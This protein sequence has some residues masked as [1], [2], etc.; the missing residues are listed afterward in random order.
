VC[1]SGQCADISTNGI[2]VSCANHGSQRY[3]ICCT[4]GRTKRSTH[5]N[6]NGI[7]QF[8]T[9]GCT[10]SITVGCSNCHTNSVSHNSAYRV[11]QR[12][13]DGSANRV[14]VFCSERSTHGWADFVANRHSNRRSICCPICGTD[15]IADRDS[16]CITFRIANGGALSSS[17]GSALCR[18]ERSPKRKPHQ[19]AFRDANCSSKRGTFIFT[20]RGSYTSTNPVLRWHGHVGRE[21]QDDFIHVWGSHRHTADRRSARCCH[22]RRV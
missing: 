20:D 16:N 7:T 10:N 15:G 5:I 19:C 8:N 12:N 22:Q 6:T 1:L 18:A 14:T 9:D 21:L 11:S 17:H 2:A 4:D 3:T 13:A